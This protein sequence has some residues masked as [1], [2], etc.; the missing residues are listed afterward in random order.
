MVCHIMKW[1]CFHQKFN[2]AAKAYLFCLLEM[3]LNGCCKIKWFV[4]TSTILIQTNIPRRIYFVLFRK[5]LPL[6]FDMDWILCGKIIYT[7]HHSCRQ[8][9]FIFEQCFYSILC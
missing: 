2:Q 4:L 1:M 8:G 7:N 6:H 3:V 9:Q 5:E